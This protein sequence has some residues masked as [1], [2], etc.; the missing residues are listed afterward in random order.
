MVSLASVVAMTVLSACIAAPFVAD[1][2]L[3]PDLLDLTSNI[4]MVPQTTDPAAP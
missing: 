3:R 4:V 1:R 2:V